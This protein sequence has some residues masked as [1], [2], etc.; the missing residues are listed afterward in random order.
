MLLNPASQQKSKLNSW[1]HWFTAS[2]TL[3]GILLMTI[4]WSAN[5]LPDSVGGMLYMLAYTIGHAGFLF[6][7]VNLL[8]L[9]P[10]TLLNKPRVA[11]IWGA[12]AAAT[13]LT[14]L[15]IDALVY[16]VYAYHIN[17]SSLDYIVSDIRLLSESLP[18]GV[19]VALA[20]FYSAMLAV[21]LVLAN[22]VWRNLD[23]FR[24]FFIKLRALPVALVCFLSAHLVHIW[25]DLNF[26]HPITQQDNMLPMSQPLTAKTILSQS[27]LLDIEEYQQK[28]QFSF[29]VSS[30][31]LKQSQQRFSCFAPDESVEIAIINSGKLSVNEISQYIQSRDLTLANT[32]YFAPNQL[33]DNIFEILTGVPA[34]YRQQLMRQGENFLDI[35]LLSTNTGAD[36]SALPDSVT[37]DLPDF[38]TLNKISGAR[39]L[40][41]FKQPENTRQIASQLK[42]QGK[43]IIVVLPQTATEYGQ[44]FVRGELIQLPPVASNLDIVP[45]LIEG[46]LSCSFQKD[47]IKFGQNLFSVPNTPAWLVT[48][49]EQNIFVL[50]QQ[51][52][53]QIEGNAQI[54]SVKMTTEE[55]ADTP[56]NAILVRALHYLKR[57][58][59]NKQANSTK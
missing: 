44:I 55:N 50:Y 53:T 31:D 52:L 36:L 6:F 4:Y 51:T 16:S 39:L 19:L 28:K 30:F 23:K 35:A 9:F 56:P 10:V 25:A 42:N 5:P 8:L 22:A 41:S 46:W 7:V 13:G 27:G 24:G 21:Q 2:N 59:V 29:D 48:A 32:R 18:T 12:I 3:P 58:L 1:G 40:V 45:T 17:L 54:R 11:R 43:Q 34:V 57:Q 37:D 38:R 14:V 20:L 15:L 49:N 47:Y 33:N 26:Y